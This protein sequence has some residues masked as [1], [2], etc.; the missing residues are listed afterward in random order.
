[1]SSRLYT[2]RLYKKRPKQGPLA[3]ARPKSFKSEAS[4]Q[5]WAKEQGLKKVKIEAIGKQGKK[6]KIRT[7]F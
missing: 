2:K 5:K 6:F 1:M 3:P 4:A 7:R